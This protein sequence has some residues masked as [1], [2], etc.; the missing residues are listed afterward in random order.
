MV[1][2]EDLVREPEA[3]LQ[4]LFDFLGVPMESQVFDQEVV[5]RGVNLGSQGFDATA[6]DRWTAS[7]SGR[8]R[9]W[10]EAT[11]GGRMRRV[12]YTD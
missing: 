2:F 10:L 8:A 1:R 9:R 4:G 5:S 3:T 6:A 7:I 11:L 12:G